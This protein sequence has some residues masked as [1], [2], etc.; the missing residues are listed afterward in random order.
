[1]N[2]ELVPILTLGLILIGLLFMLWR[3]ARADYQALQAENSALRAEFRAE[4][5][6]QRADFNS[7]IRHLREE[8][9]ADNQRLR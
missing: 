4:I 7:Q 1:M 9:R 5:Q 2:P 6:S 8:L 3:D